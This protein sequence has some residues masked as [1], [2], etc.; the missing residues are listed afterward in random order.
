MNNF[1]VS[2]IYDALEYWCKLDFFSQEECPKPFSREDFQKE[3]RKS[4]KSGATIGYR[5]RAEYDGRDSCPGD[6]IARRLN[7]LLGNEADSRNCPFSS[8]TYVYFGRVPRDA[9]T[10]FLAGTEYKKRVEQDAS[11]I[12]AALFRLNCGGTFGGLEISPILWMTHKG[13]GKS[14]PNIGE[15]KSEEKQW[16]KTIAAA[17]ESQV[18]SYS[19]IRDIAAPYVV[20]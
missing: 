15:Y 6:T 12:S 10:S 14:L 2:Q 8:S 20:P 1:E 19:D 18:L 16:N 7:K 3:R 9:A 5:D 4:K 11:E 17:Y 13:V